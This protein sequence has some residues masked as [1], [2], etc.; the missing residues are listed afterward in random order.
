MRK[1]VMAGLATLTIATAIGWI[2]SYGGFRGSFFAS[3]TLADDGGFILVW[4][5]GYGRLAAECK[6]KLQTPLAS[7]T[8]VRRADHLWVSRGTSVRYFDLKRE[9]PSD[10][11]LKKLLIGPSGNL[12]APTIRRGKKLFVGFHREP[13]EAEMLS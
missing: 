1:V 12:R 13:Y 3:Q 2:C 11:E 9:P 6:Y 5:V 8:Q 10:A 7:P 4:T